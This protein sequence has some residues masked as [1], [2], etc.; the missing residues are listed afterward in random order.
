MAGLMHHHR[1]FSA[2]KPARESGFYWSY[3][4]LQHQYGNMR[5]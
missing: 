5:E 2:A 4:A 1:F 3:R